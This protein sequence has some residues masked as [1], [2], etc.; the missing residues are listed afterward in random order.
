MIYETCLKIFV[1]AGG[2]NPLYFFALTILQFSITLWVIVRKEIN[3]YTIV[4]ANMYPSFLFVLLCGAEIAD[5]F[6]S[7][8]AVG[9][10]YILEFA[11][12]LMVVF[13]MLRHAVR[14]KVGQLGLINKLVVLA[15]SFWQVFVGFV[16]VAFWQL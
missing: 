8:S 6:Q 15:C 11:P 16:F 2:S 12:S 4:F 13:N 5:R 7:I 10:K 1:F 14:A 9:D 3:F